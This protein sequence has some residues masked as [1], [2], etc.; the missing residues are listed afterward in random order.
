M[1]PGGDGG[2][3]K[4][5]DFTG[6]EQSPAIDG[7]KPWKGSVGFEGVKPTHPYGELKFNDLPG[8]RAPKPDSSGNGDNDDSRRRPK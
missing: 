1:G 2:G 6:P 4:A 5:G 8:G 3:G 7:T